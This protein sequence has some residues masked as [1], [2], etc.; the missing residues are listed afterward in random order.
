MVTP[1]PTIP[2]HKSAQKAG[3]AQMIVQHPSSNSATK[4]KRAQIQF[5]KPFGKDASKVP[6]AP[7]KLGSDAAGAFR[8]VRQSM[9]P[10]LG[11]DPADL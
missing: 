4:Y 3:E 8:K 5:S 11:V 10:P 2:K 9:R 7:K 6:I 1:G